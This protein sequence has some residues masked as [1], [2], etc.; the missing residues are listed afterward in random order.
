MALDPLSRSSLAAVAVLVATAHVAA[1]NC[2]P[3]FATLFSCKIQGRAQYVEYCHAPADEQGVIRSYSYN[4][5]S[6]FGPAEL[7]FTSGANGLI[8][9]YLDP[10]RSDAENTLGFSL[11]NGNHQYAFF[12]TGIFGERIRAAQIHVYDSIDAATS[13]RTENEI[14]RLYCE[15]ESVRVNWDHIRP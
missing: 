9:K 7:Y 11:G 5:T 4:F 3:P 13:D 2:N 12:I 14:S 8:Y 6:G 10:K 15:T 1:A